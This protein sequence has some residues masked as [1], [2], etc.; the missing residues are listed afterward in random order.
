[1][2]FLAQRRIDLG[3]VIGI[4]L[5]AIPL[6]LHFEVRPL[7][8][9]LFFFVLPTVYLFIRRQKPILRVFSGALVIG[10]GPGLIFDIIASYNTAWAEAPSQLVFKF[11]LFGFLPLDEPIWFFLLALY[12]L[13]FYEHFFERESKG[14]LSL[15]FS[16][17][18]LTMIILLL[19]TV[20]LVIFFPAV[21]SFGFAYALVAAVFTLIMLFF[22]RKTLFKKELLVRY[23]KTTVFFFFL[24]LV[25]ELTAVHLSQ[26]FFPGQYVGYVELANIRFPFEELFFWM[27]IST[28]LILA[29]YE[30]FVDDERQMG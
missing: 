11:L 30:G 5:L 14:K 12:V 16:K 26:W 19:L 9:A 10:L 3:V 20:F 24:Y 17:F 4:S 27:L 13:T 23:L 7:T 8:S 18:L 25:Y 28:V 22:A 1:M 21:L 15:R 6:I 2:T 29:V